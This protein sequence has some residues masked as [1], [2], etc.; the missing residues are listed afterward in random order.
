MTLAILT[1][2]L[3][4]ATVT[5]VMAKDV[6]I[7]IIDGKDWYYGDESSGGD[8]TGVNATVTGTTDE[9]VYVY[10][11]YASGDYNATN[12]TVNFLADKNGKVNLW[13]YGGYS[14]FGDAT[15][16]TVMISSGTASG[17]V[18]GGKSVKGD[19][20]GNTVMISGGTVSGRVYGGESS[21]GDAT[22]NKII[23]RA[24]ENGETATFG[25]HTILDGYSGSGT[26]SDNAL[27]FQGVKNVEAGKVNYF[28]KYQFLLGD[29]FND[30]D[31]FLNLTDSLTD[32]T[33]GR[34]AEACVAYAN[35]DDT[36][37][38]MKVTPYSSG[39][40]SDG[41]KLVPYEN[42]AKTASIT[43]AGTFDTTDNNTV[44]KL[45]VADV[46]YKFA[47]SDN[48][49]ALKNGDAFFTFKRKGTLKVSSDQ[50]T[51]QN[52]KLLLSEGDKIYLLKNDEAMGKLEYTATDD[53]QKWVNTYKNEK[54]TVTTTSAVNQVDN[55]LVLSVS[56][57][58]YAFD[59]TTAKTGDAAFL[60]SQNA[61][62]TTIAAKNVDITG[63][64]NT[65]LNI[66]KGDT[67]YL[68]ENTT[69]TGK[70]AYTG[71]NTWTHNYEATTDAGTATVATTGTVKADGNDLKLNIDEQTYAFNLSADAK[72]N[73]TFLTSTNTGT[74]KIYDLDLTVANGSKLQ[75]GDTV[76][77]LKNT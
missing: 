12:N 40:S 69:D 5:P 15:G 60:T 55:D 19:A 9:I 54:A 52:G 64:Q 10:G 36:I 35:A 6:T 66:N 13:M 1:A 32:R 53:A 42:E 44:L 46:A 16:N 47:I 24:G 77:L 68:L 21:D 14:A 71:S 75:P 37:S 45:K 58:K 63:N 30:T 25:K 74:T 11:G 34:N 31:V 33:M 27:I 2:L 70:L 48:A 22:G 73:D 39:I 56:D 62:T 67:F 26:G 41:L 7:D 57:V 38:L 43:T 61:G 23:I 51:F 17:N 8:V 18:F 76:Y 65:L 50:V 28:D 72:N 3:A 20:T 49:N 59:L 4:G 29:D